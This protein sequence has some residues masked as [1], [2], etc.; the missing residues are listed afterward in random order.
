MNHNEIVAWGKNN[1]QNNILNKCAVI[2]LRDSKENSKI[3]KRITT[4]KTVLKIHTKHIFD[5]FPS[6]KSKLARIISLVYFG[7]YL[8]YYLSIINKI[9]PTPIPAI[10]YLKA[11]ISK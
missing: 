4:T 7:D 6:G 2:F 10:D 9:D 11:Q 1:P 5:I 8:S 3:S